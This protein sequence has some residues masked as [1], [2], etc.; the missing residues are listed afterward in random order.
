MPYPKIP[1]FAYFLDQLSLYS[2]LK[3]EYGA[4]NISSI[5]ATVEKTLQSALVELQNLPIDGEQ[6]RQEPDDLRKIQS[7]RPAGPRRL[8]SA[9]DEVR[10]RE[11]LEGALLGR[12]AGCILGAPVEFW[13][14]A[15]MEALAKETGSP[16][17]PEDYW[18]YVPEP[19]EKR[20]GMSPRQAYTRGH[21]DGV[22]VDDD[23]AYTLLGLLIA[24]EAGPDF[25][26]ADV[27]R[28]WLKYLPYACTAEEVALK[29]LQAG[30]PAS[31]AAAKNNPFCEWIGADIR[32][33]PWGYLAAGW[34][35]KAAAMAYQ[36]AYLSHRR[37][38][39]YGEMYFAAAIAAAFSVDHP[40]EALEIGLSEIPEECSLAKAIHWALKLAPDIHNYRQAREAMKERFKGMNPVH[41]INNACL[42]I[43][44]I[45]IGGT[46]FSRVIGET[47]AMGMD[48]DCTAATAGSIV[49]AIVG[50]QGIPQKW[51]SNFNDTVH[52]YLIGKERFSIKDLMDRFTRLTFRVYQESMVK[53]THT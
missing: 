15:K 21:M 27:G 20:Y 48:N 29:N 34:P 53:Q 23:I 26:T 22:P 14:V 52:A 2:Q 44:G 46:D 51:Y 33:D 36:D 16:F 42:T 30:V 13:S 18:S 19:F 9:F 1:D 3:H 39:I 37:Q 4:G 32:A 49:G 31:E 24:E 43:W 45:A 28:A 41:T 8:W 17:P 40:M 5:L 47:V 35:E 6:A 25:T 50:R 12:M 7:L 38:G 11:R 10:Y